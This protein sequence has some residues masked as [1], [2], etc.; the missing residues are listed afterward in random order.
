MK[1]I[2]LYGRQAA[3]RVALIDD[4]DFELVSQ[5]RWR[6]RE[7][8][9]ANGRIDGPY[10]I[11]SARSGGRKSSVF[12]HKLIT[13]WPMTDHANGDGLDNR[14]SNLRPATPAQNN[15]NQR[16]HRGKSSR[17]K[18]VT[19]HKKCRK[20]Q[21]SIKIG[22]RNQYLGLFV[23][24]EDAAAAYEAA[25]LQSQAEYAYAA[26]PETYPRDEFPV[27]ISA[28][29]PPMPMRVRQ[30][31]APNGLRSN[32][33]SGVCGVVYAPSISAPKPWRAQI[34]VN[35]KGIYLGIFATK[36]EAA[37]ARRE[38]ELRYYGEAPS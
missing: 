1:A 25:A 30:D 32:N 6:A 36:E 27:I 31:K 8:D 33:T 37:A 28:V 21:A 11:A 3:G 17:Y 22:D 13:G 16:P 7:R 9:N 10:A 5:Y 35:R 14:R 2:P 12:M 19:W 34:M 24:E 4:E 20:W 15:Y 29:T 23:S 38:A 18:G 26:R